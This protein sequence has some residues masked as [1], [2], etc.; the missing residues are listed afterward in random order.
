VLF[1]AKNISLESQSHL[2]RMNPS[3]RW[4]RYITASRHL[5]RFCL[6]RFCKFSAFF[7]AIMTPKELVA[8][9]IKYVAEWGVQLAS[10]CPELRQVPTGWAFVSDSDNRQIYWVNLNTGDATSIHPHYGSL[11]RD[12]VLRVYSIDGGGYKARYLNIVTGEVT[13][14]VGFLNSEYP[15]SCWQSQPTHAR[16]P[17]LD[18]FLPQ[19]QILIQLP[20]SSIFL[21]PFTATVPRN[22]KGPPHISHHDEERRSGSEG[23]AT[24]ADWKKQCKRSI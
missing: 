14:Q 20:G 7:V 9:A 11:P 4:V 8:L 19:L 17:A 18:I 12:W 1:T 6:I 24:S 5:Y 15:T 3:A 2:C 16:N 10:S 13:Q 23:N 21:R 22:F